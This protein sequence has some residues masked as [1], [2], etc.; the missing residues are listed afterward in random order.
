VSDAALD[1]AHVGRRAGHAGMFGLAVG[2]LGIVY[3]D[4]GTSPLYALREAFEH[5]DLDVDSTSTYGV[6]SIVFWALVIIISIKYLALVMRADNHGEGGILAL[7]ALLIPRQQQGSAS[8]RATRL[9]G[10]AAA[11]VTLGVFGTAL[12]Y[13]D[14]LITPAISV[15]SAVEGFEVATTAFADWVLPVSVAILVALFSV[16]SRGTAGI[17]RIFGPVMVVW[18][19]VVGVLGLRQVIDHPGV[20]KAVWPGYALDFFVDRPGK[21]FLSLGSIF[22]VVTGGEALYADMGHFG[23]RPIQL[24]WYTWVFPALLLN[25][26]GQAA[27]LSAD[28]AAIESPF[29]RLAPDWAITPLAILATMATVIAS[30]ALIS[31]AFS[32]TAQAIQLDYIP[33]LAVRHTSGEH[34]GQIYVPLVNWLLMLGCVGLVL[35]FRSSSALASAYGIAVTATMAITTLL[36]FKVVQSRFGWSATK[37]TLVLMPLLAVDLAFLA[38][39]VPKIPDGGWF[40]LLIAV[41]LVIQMT[42]WRR[43]RDLVAARLRRAEVPM[44]TTMANLDPAI[45]RV[46]G[47]AVYLFKDAEAT[48]PA[49][50]ANLKHHTVLHEHVLLLA[51]DV[52]ESAYVGESQG[53]TVS[54]LGSGVQQVVICHGF[55]EEPDVRAA[56]A[57]VEVAGKPVD[58]AAV[59]YFLGD[60]MVVATDI[61]GM[62]PWREHLFVLLDRGADSAARFF[63][64]PADRVVTVGT[65]VE[66]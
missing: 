66:I 8:W 54:S 59:T 7:T 34:A 62:H 27:L 55:M 28:P 40:P 63:D 18:F 49:L 39:N 24:S 12:L 32:M 11:A 61:E 44:T 53:V 37:A 43:G 9:T 5:N 6:A 46:P 45:T 17:A 51:I 50:L 64:L 26:F 31:G 16:Q 30:Q 48:P 36:F 4:I 35:G 19:A 33:R 57:S 2:A 42:T 14:G 60:E 38:A 41:V 15:L 3:G 47:T 22:L 65:H 13:G 56:I 29:Y 23:R 52:S 20:L 1:D 21:A 10:V 25:Y 58:P